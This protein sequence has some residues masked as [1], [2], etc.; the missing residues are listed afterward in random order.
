MRS[1]CRLASKGPP[2]PSSDGAAWPWVSPL[3][4]HD[5]PRQLVE[6]RRISVQGSSR[7]ISRVS[8]QRLSA[9]V[10]RHLRHRAVLRRVC[11]IVEQDADA[12]PGDRVELGLE[13]AREHHPPSGAVVLPVV[14]RA[15]VAPASN[16]PAD[17]DA[18]AVEGE[19]PPL[20]PG[21]RGLGEVGA[22]VEDEAAK[23]GGSEAGAPVAGRPR[24]TRL[25]QLEDHH[26]SRL[27]GQT[28]EELVRAVVA[29]CSLTA[30]AGEDLAVA[31]VPR[32][33]VGLA[34]EH[35]V[36]VGPSLVEQDGRRCRARSE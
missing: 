27:G 14:A 3:W 29:P 31:A 11:R 2:C 35:R 22:L 25:G 7:R 8:Q 1:A 16:A 10:P 18:V 26:A 28:G 9:T 34:E 23:D 20:A 32:Q 13:H 21:Q 4:E 5:G 24:A 12:A 19:P 15:V 33:V 30:S 36:A 6:S 17:S